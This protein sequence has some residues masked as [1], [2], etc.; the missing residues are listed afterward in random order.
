[1]RRPRGPEREGSDV[2]DRHAR[3]GVRAAFASIPATPARRVLQPARL[4]SHVQRTTWDGL[5]ISTEP[6]Y[7][8]TVVVYRG[9]GAATEVLLLHRAHHGPEYAG[10]WAWTPPAGARLPGEHIEECA[11]RELRE[12]TG[13]DLPLRL[14]ECGAADWP[15]FV[16][17]AA[18][19]AAIVL[20]AEHDR[21]EWAAADQAPRQC[22]PEEVRAPLTAT[23]RTVVALGGGAFY[24]DDRVFATYQAHRARSSN[25]NDTIEEP[26]FVVVLGEV[27]GLRVLDLGCG[28]GRFGA[29]LLGHGC[30]H[31]VGVEA[32]RNMLHLAQQTLD[33]TRSVV[34]AGR[35]ED[36]VPEPASFDVV[37]SRLALHYVEDLEPVFGRARRALVDSGRLVFTV[38]HPVITSSD[39]AWQ[40][41]GQ[42]Q[43]WLVDDYFRTGRRETNWLGARV[44]KFHRTIDDYV[45]LVEA[46]GLELETLHEPA[47]RPDRVGED[48]FRRRQR[49]P[50]FLLLSARVRVVPGSPRAAP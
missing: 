39:A 50:L 20:D 16:A 29:R 49:I 6:P 3:P 33:G 43:A 36:F 15:H 5:P 28:D 14:T 9:H 7:G 23:L 25:P 35:I 45:R 4:P 34:H 24:D 46:A 26:A 38:E 42:R 18:H 47:P 37:V 44:V 1:L 21:F 8:A 12:E 11:R 10:D 22:L 30:A 27:R 31:Y 2:R 32:S 13:L 19:D 41:R 17:E 48:E 40:G